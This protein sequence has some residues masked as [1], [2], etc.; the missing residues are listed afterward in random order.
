M[1][2]LGTD[3][4]KNALIGISIGISTISVL[5]EPVESCEE[6]SLNQHNRTR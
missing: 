4:L 5:L 6:V 3:N 1:S 2:F